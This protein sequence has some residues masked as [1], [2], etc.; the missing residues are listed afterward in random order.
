MEKIHGVNLG[1]W[2]VLEKWMDIR[3]F[4]NTGA[5]D[6]I[7]LSRKLDR[8]TL[9]KKVKEHRDTFITERDFQNIASHGVNLVRI[10]VPYF[11]FGDREPL[12]GGIE[13]LDKA[14]D[15]ANQYG[16]QILLDLH[17]VPGSQNGYDNGGITGVCKWSKSP[18]E[19]EFALSVLERLATRYGDNE[20]LYGIQPLNEPIS[21]LVWVTSPS[22]NK[23]LDKD[24]AKGSSYVSMSFLKGFYLK[25][26]KRLR[27]ILPEDKV[28]V[29]HDGFRLKKWKKFFTENNLKNVM[30]D[31]HIYI[32]A[33]EGFLPIP[34]F[35][36]YKAYVNMNKRT[37]RKV[38]SYVPVVVGEWCISNKYA[39]NAESNKKQEKYRQVADLQLKAWDES[40]GFIYWSYKLWPENDIPMDEDWKEAWDLRRDWERGYMPGDFKTLCYK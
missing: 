1:N 14:F 33:M 35:R 5:D 18:E 12:P 31:T 29:F 21:F 22:F 36:V 24:E 27:E 4:E 9:H 3:I 13:Y 15:W 23:A 10:P 2:L 8:E 25:A 26:Y 30:L 32:F 39:G 7:W 11:I 16:L 20:A 37:I 40:A 34:S 6:E 17:T 38:A 28:I 19:V